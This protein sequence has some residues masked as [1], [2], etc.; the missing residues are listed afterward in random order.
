MAYPSTVASR[1][2][3]GSAK[4]S[5]LTTTLSS[6]YVETTFTISDASTW[7]EVGTDGQATSNPLG[8]SGTFEVCVDFGT[9]SEE[10]ILCS[11]VSVSTGVVTIWTDGV[12]NGRGWGTPKLSLIHI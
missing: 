3:S 11:G 12:R 1:S 2:I 9:A 10:H 6:T 8:T 5:Y 4:P 7:Y